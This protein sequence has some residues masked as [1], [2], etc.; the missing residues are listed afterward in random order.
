MCLESGSSS[1]HERLKQLPNFV[2]LK[3]SSL[4]N[5]QHICKDLFYSSS[6]DLSVLLQLT[7]VKSRFNINQFLKLANDR[8]NKHLSSD[9]IQT[10]LG[11]F[12]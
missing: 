4:K 7:W 3:T 12:L 9:T 1:P 10:C 5:K 2:P 6:H 8:Y 11:P